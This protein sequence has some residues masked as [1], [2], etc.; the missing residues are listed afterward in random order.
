MR[1]T[2]IVAAMSDTIIFIH[3][4]WLASNSW[5]RFA[6]FF[7]ERGY[8]TLAPE[9]P[10]KSGDVAAL[11]ESAADAAGLGV[12]EIV[13]HYAAI[14]EELDDQPIVIGHSFGGLIT[15]ILLGRGTGRAAVAMDPAA[16]KGVKRVPSSPALARASAWP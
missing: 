8:A 11:R 12:A 16:P 7:S 13:D 14:I 6:A 4:A 3:G 15:Q 2:R 10:R 9:W 5:D 1:G